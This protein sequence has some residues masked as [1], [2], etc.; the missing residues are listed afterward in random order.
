MLLAKLWQASVDESAVTAAVTEFRDSVDRLNPLVGTD[1]RVAEFRAAL[2]TPFDSAAFTGQGPVRAGWRLKPTMAGHDDTAVFYGP[3]DPISGVAPLIEFR[4][5]TPAGA[6][7]RPFFLSSTEVSLQQAMTVLN[8][9]PELRKLLGAAGKKFDSRVQVWCI[10]TGGLVEQH[11]GWLTRGDI[12]TPPADPPRDYPMQA[13]PPEAAIGIARSLGCRLPTTD[14]W[15]A[16]VAV[17]QDDWAKR[18]RQKQPLGWKLRDARWSNRGQASERFTLETGIFVPAGKQDLMGLLSTSDSVWLEQGLAGATAGSSRTARA[19]GGAR[20][21]ESLHDEQRFML[22]D[23]SVAFRKV[24]MGSFVPLYSGFHDLV[25]NVA[26]YT[27]ESPLAFAS[28][29]T[30]CSA[31]E[32]QEFTGR[33]K[34]E[35]HIIGGSAFSPPFVKYS[36]PN[37]VK[38]ESAVE[39]F[40]D[41]GFRLAYSEV[42][43]PRVAWLHGA[44]EKSMYLTADAV[45]QASAK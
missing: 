3:T 7:A 22:D 13:I 15:R 42:S 27:M 12:V 26:E 40:A 32:L 16:A 19:L 21:G 33:H 41:V 9:A 23:L 18:Y 44:L 36:E 24:A 5:V 35:L 34:D 30:H 43:E 4:R 10:K 1:L 45:S 11:N 39:G 37:P 29:P 2:E 25:G 20:P 28:L 14:E 6:K 8:A 31:R 17:E 38:L